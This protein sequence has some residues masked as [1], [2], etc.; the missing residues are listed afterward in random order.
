MEEITSVNNELVKETAKL[1]QKK[2][3]DLS[4]NFLLEGYKSIE[5]A[6]KA[7]IKIEYIF[8]LQ[9]VYAKYQFCN[10]RIISAS[11]AVLKKISAA[12]SAPEAVGVAKQIHHDIEKLKNAKKII[13]LE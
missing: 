6:V 2:F 12:E 7:G 1:Q 9:K 13:L 10:C 11:E 8:V 5:E 4:G 3:R